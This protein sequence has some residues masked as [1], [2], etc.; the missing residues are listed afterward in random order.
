MIKAQDMLALG[1]ADKMFPNG[2]FYDMS[3][4]L[5]VDLIEGKAKIDRK[6][7]DWS[8]L[9]DLYTAAKAF[10]DGNVHG[11]AIAPYKALELIKGAKDWDLDKGF[12]EESKA[13]GELII[14]DQCRAGVYSFDLVQ[15]RA[16]KPVGVPEVPPAKIVKI[17]VIG[18]GLMGAQIATLFLQRYE[19]P[20]VMKDIKQE[21]VDKG[22]KY[23]H[24]QV[25]KMVKKGKVNEGKGIW[26]KSLVKGSLDY[27]D[28]G[29][30]NYIIEAV[31]EEMPLKKKVFAEVEAHIKP[32]TILA[33]NTS[34]LSIT[35]MAKDLKNP[36][37]V[38]GF[39]FF[40]PVAV[41]PLLEIIKGAKT[42]DVTVATAF[43]M[44][45]KIKKTSILVKD[46]A[47]F[48]VNRLLMRWMGEIVKVVDEG[49][50]SFKEI[51]EYCVSLGFPM[52]PFALLALVG[53]AVG[54]HV[55]E[56]LNKAFG[57][58]FY[59]SPGL[60]KMVEMKKP[61]VYDWNGNEDPDVVA[62]WPRGGKKF[63]KQE[64]IDRFLTGTTE[65]C[66]MIL[67]EGVVSNAKDIDTC[68]IMGAGWPF[69]MGGITKY[70]DQKGYSKKVT[71]KLLAKDE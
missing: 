66:R 56:T 67:D 71:G 2:E 58:R 27:K 32:E 68:M 39:H 60:K 10:I 34:S 24:D 17:G 62:N 21:F 13:L 5:L 12:D 36:E 57:D 30:C 51:D 64:V 8:K 42:N 19:C 48:M 50:N 35:E 69:F 14:S 44:G 4:D 29:D 28:F 47:A 65:E 43:A 40:N 41:M 9:N 55:A 61:G 38:V 1:I 23:V 63:T 70:L 45:K 18:A 31:L 25:D 3:F 52:T 53:P 15:R 7:A 37:R 49:N 16:K 6:P 20:I 22:L 59:I 26:L 33:T 11:A 54:L 46:S